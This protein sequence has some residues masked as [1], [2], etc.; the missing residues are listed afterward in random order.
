MINNNG[1][2]GVCLAYQIIENRNTEN[3]SLLS[4]EIRISSAFC[5]SKDVYCKKIGREKATN[6]MNTGN[7]FSMPMKG[8][9]HSRRERIQKHLPFIAAN[10]NVLFEAQK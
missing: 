6:N 7:Y 9:L 8:T 5:S 1:K 3:N 10:L 2:G 4:R